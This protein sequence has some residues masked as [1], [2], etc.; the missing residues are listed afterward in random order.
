MEA[1][2]SNESRKRAKSAKKRAVKI[3]RDVAGS[4]EGNMKLFT[5]TTFTGCYPAGTSA[6][7]WAVNKESAAKKLNAVLIEDGF[8]GDATPEDMIEFKESKNEAAVLIL[9]NGDF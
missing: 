4:D 2:E 9:N 1:N 7:V 5:N 8:K 6:V 3:K